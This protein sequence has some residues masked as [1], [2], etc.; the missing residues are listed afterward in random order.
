MRYRSDG[1]GHSVLGRQL[2][3]FFVLAYGL[4]WVFFG[5]LPLSRPGLGWLPF[6]L[7]LPVMIVVGSFAPSVA[8]LATLRITEG[9]WPAVA[10]FATKPTL[11]GFVIAPVL[12]A[13]TFAAIPAAILTRGTLSSLHW[14]VLLSGSVYSLSSLIGGPLG[15]EPGWRGF[16]LPRLEEM[17]GPWRA[18]LLLGFLRAAWHLPLF[19][20]KAWSSTG[21]PTYLKIVGIKGKASDWESI[22]KVGASFDQSSV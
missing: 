14:G 9:R 13:G 12:I 6:D 21:F 18:S 17:Y 22:A 2:V 4:A 3:L 5:S 16:A 11:V 19:L 15:E 7:S 1:G 8:A 10:P 20:C